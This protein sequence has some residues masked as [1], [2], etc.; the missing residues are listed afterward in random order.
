MKLAFNMVFPYSPMTKQF[1][2]LTYLLDISI[3]LFWLNH[4]ILKASHASV[5]RKSM[6]PVLLGILTFQ[7]V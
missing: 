3:N 2:K 4:N 1:I 7:E 5:I 6:N